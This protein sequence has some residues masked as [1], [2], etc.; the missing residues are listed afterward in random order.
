MHALFFATWDEFFSSSP[1]VPLRIS[2]MI[3]HYYCLEWGLEM[4]IAHVQISN[5][6]TASK[7]NLLQN[8][9]MNWTLGAKCGLGL[10]RP[11]WSFISITKLF[12]IIHSVFTQFLFFQ[13]S[14]WW[15]LGSFFGLVHQVDGDNHWLKMAWRE[16]VHLNVGTKGRMVLNHR[17]KLKHKAKSHVFINEESNDYSKEELQWLTKCTIKSEP[18]AI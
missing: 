12:G 11:K 9:S 4:N 6:M 13:S 5:I 14:A 8:Q 17:Q 7:A 10:E 18:E 2:V 3:I 1:S 16:K 15:K